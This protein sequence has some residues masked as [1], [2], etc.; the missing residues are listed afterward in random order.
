MCEILGFTAKK[1][2][3][4]QKILKAFF[5]N[6]TLHPD[7]WGCAIYKNGLPTVI[8]EPMAAYKST[9]AN[10]LTNDKLI[11]KL[12]IAH[13]RKAT[14]GKVNINNCHPFVRNVNGNDIV[15]AHNGTVK[16]NVTGYCHERP[17]GDTDSE[18]VLCC[19]ADNLAVSQL[20]EV[21]IYEETIKKLSTEGKLNLLFSDGEQLFIHTNMEG[22]LYRLQGDGYAIF[23]TKP[24]L[25]PKNGLNWEPVPLNRL[26]IYKDGKEIYQSELLRKEKYIEFY[27]AYQ[28][29][30]FKRA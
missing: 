3:D 4:I 9:M 14:R 22:T 1:E 20:S 23:A 2:Y 27:P 26:F 30:K 21:M 13:I 18:R 25:E 19:I 16:A 17:V 24:V 10:A 7:G 6:S 11:T 5:N 29:R 28:N 12:A 15:L 8:K